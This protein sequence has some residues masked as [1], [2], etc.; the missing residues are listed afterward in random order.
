MK[1]YY[2]RRKDN[3]NII[4]SFG[5]GEPGK[6][7][8]DSEI[9]E[10]VEGNLPEG[11]ETE[12]RKKTLL[13]KKN[14]I[15]NLYLSLEKAHRKVLADVAMKVST[16]LVNNDLEIAIDTVEEFETP[17]GFESIKT[18]ILEVLNSN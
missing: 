5:H 15:N 18:K 6:Y 12:K 13:D 14:E 16:A 2:V 1:H 4:L 7:V 10:E 11:F 9:Y 8:F 3:Q 17:Q